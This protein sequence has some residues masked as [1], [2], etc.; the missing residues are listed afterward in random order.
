M[1][2]IVLFASGSGTNAE[3]IALYFRTI[4]E[5]EVSCVL[6]NRPDAGVLERARKLN[7]DTKVFDREMF[8]KS[9]QVLDF[10]LDINPDLIVL[11]GFLWLVPK[12]IVEAFPNRI[13]NI[14]PAL[15]PKYGGRGMYGDRVHQ[16]VID[17]GD[18]ETGIS[19]HYVN[20][21]Y[22]EGDIIFQA[23]C[24]VDSDDTP[25][26]LAKKVHELEYKHYPAV[27]HQLLKKQPFGG[28]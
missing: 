28:E 26:S 27:I 16:A 8:F 20:E 19:I 15:L 25:E 3:N 21:E 1:K 14:H 10:L 17:N 18:K 9:R 24:P 13:V 22:D 6:S 7:I 4:P 23:R 2:N 5:A 12:H 11:A